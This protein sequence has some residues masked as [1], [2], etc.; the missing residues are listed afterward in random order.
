MKILA[1][2]NYKHIKKNFDEEDF[3][4]IK[5]LITILNE[6]VTGEADLTVEGKNFLVEFYGSSKL[7]EKIVENGGLD[8]V[9][10]GKNAA[11]VKET[12]DSIVPMQTINF[13]K[14]SQS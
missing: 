14:E 7:A 6:V 5:T 13:I 11:V 8:E 12:I 4:S 2:R 10:D 1:V 3:K 9:T